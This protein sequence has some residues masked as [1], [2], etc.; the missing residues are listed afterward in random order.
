[1]KY[2]ISF[3]DE[4]AATTHLMMVCDESVEKMDMYLGWGVSIAEKHLR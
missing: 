1:M 4:T 2:V 3:I